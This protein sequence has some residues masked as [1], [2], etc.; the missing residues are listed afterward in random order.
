[1]ITSLSSKYELT[2]ITVLHPRHKLSYFKTTRWEEEWITTAERLVR[3]E[4]ARSYMNIEA[5]KDINIVEITPD[6]EID[7]KV[8]RLI[9]SLQLTDSIVC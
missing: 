7:T 1:M 8:R 9:I 2:C 5:D 3:D 6:N 4:F